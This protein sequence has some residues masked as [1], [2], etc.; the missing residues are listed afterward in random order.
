MENI[1]VANL[2]KLI[3]RSQDQKNIFSLSEF[4]RLTDTIL[5]RNLNQ[6]ELKSLNN[7]MT[8]FARR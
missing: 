7:L 8:H 3:E 4:M 1:M 2:D 5:E 6:D